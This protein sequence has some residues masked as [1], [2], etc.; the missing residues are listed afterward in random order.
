MGSKKTEDTKYI[1]SSITYYWHSWVTK[2]V[3][4]N[5]VLIFLETLPG[6]ESLAI[7]IKSLEN[8]PLKPLAYEPQP[9][10]FLGERELQHYFSEVN[11]TI[12]SIFSG[13][14]LWY[15]LVS[16]HQ[17][18]SRLHRPRKVFSKAQYSYY[19]FILQHNMAIHNN[20][21]GEKKNSGCM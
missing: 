15:C 2:N 11:N 14:N 19:G 16:V 4:S 18:V 21:S 10:H 3:S 9:T 7:F 13:N 17:R 12:A 1:P 20:I 8:F 5:K 6:S